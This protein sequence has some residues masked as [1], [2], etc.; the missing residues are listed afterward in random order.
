MSDATVVSR[1][2]IGSPG[3][4]VQHEYSIPSV[5]ASDSDGIES[6]E[7][8]L[9]LDKSSGVILSHRVVCASENFDF[10]I[11]GK[12]GES[13]PSLWDVISREGVN[14]KSGTTGIED[15]FISDDRKLY[16]NLKNND[17]V[18][19]TGVISILLKISY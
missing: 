5:E 18:N 7:Y 6:G 1:R 16:F 12:S 13:D 14:K 19:A 4:I 10:F 9:A 11:R 15:P 8:G 17:S 3:G 2:S